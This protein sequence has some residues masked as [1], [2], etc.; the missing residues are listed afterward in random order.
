MKYSKQILLIACLVVSFGSVAQ[1]RVVHSAVPATTVSPTYP[2]VGVST[3]RDFSEDLALPK[4][5]VPIPSTNLK[6]AVTPQQ[7]YSPA[8]SG[9]TYNAGELQRVSSGQVISVGGGVS[10]GASGGAVSVS[11]SYSAPAISVVSVNPL[12]VRKHRDFVSA[13]AVLSTDEDSESAPSKQR[14]PLLPEEDDLNDSNQMGAPITDTP[15]LLL[16]LACAAFVGV[17]KVRNLRQ[18]ES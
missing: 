8:T 10:A 18:L 11:G 13:D 5:E 4:V 15:W 2:T 17:R 3:E 7:L 16:L 12:P 9:V 14:L 6:P 1:T